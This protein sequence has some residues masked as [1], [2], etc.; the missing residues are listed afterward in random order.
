MFIKFDRNKIKPSKIIIAWLVGVILFTVIKTA[1]LI[2]T[3]SGGEQAPETFIAKMISVT[4]Y[5][6]LVI[7]IV[8][9]T[10]TKNQSSLNISIIIC[11]LLLLCMVFIN[12]MR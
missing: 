2:S 5:G 4:V 3:T 1:I 10:L 8:M 12:D 11:C 9:L 7:S 6:L